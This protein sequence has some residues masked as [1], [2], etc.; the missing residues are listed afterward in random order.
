MSKIAK[1]HFDTRDKQ[2]RFPDDDKLREKGY[3]I[4]SRPNRGEALWKLPGCEPVTQSEAL[5][6]IREWE[7]MRAAV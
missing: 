7:R 6:S 4:V 3:V 2:P 1:R 5:R